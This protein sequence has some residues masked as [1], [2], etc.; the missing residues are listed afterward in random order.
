MAFFAMFFLLAI[1][2]ISWLLVVYKFIKNLIYING[3]R[4]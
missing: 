1:V 2:L 3:P 4:N